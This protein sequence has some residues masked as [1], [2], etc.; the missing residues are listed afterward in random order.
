MPEP[1]GPI[2]RAQR[3]DGAY[4]PEIE[5]EWAY[6]MPFAADV[7]QAVARPIRGPAR[8]GRSSRPLL[9]SVSCQL[10]NDIQVTITAP[11]LLEEVRDKTF[12]VSSWNA[13]RRTL[14]STGFTWMDLEA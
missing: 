8:S 4:P 7:S 6:L 9:R 12:V 2:T 1:Y 13:V 14:F 5:M 3:L 10:H 11:T